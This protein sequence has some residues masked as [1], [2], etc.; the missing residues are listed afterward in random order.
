[1]S[2]PQ[3]HEGGRAIE[4]HSGKAIGGTSTI[5]GKPHTIS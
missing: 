1:M 4:Y 3:T 5:N 2:V